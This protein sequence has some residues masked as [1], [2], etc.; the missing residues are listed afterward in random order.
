MIASLDELAAALARS[1]SICLRKASVPLVAN[2]IADL[3]LAGAGFPAAGSPPAGA[4]GEMPSN[5]TAGALPF[6]DPI[7]GN[8]TLV[9]RIAA[10]S[11]A[12]GM[13]SI[14]DRIWH[15]AIGNGWGTE[16]I[17]IAWPTGAQR[18]AD[19]TGVELYGAVAAPLGS[20]TPATW[21][22]GFRDQAG[23][24]RTATAAFDGAGPVGRMVP[25]D[26]PAGVTGI[27]RVESFEASAAQASG[28][29][30]LVLC[31]RLVDVPLLANTPTA[32]DGIALG[33]PAVEPAACLFPILFL[34]SAAATGPLTAKL[35]LVQG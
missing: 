23:E 8:A 7:A 30:S 29:L 13:L 21:T 6:R 1:Q 28:T 33:L 25:F 3:F 14:A 5:A 31:K 20:A 16:P 19:G 24:L 9:G 26:L 32:Q 18:H 35:D 2:G 27:T 4:D 12:S 34:G 22:V 10:L 17:A 15:D 11:Q